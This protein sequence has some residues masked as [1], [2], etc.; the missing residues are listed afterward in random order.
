[1]KQCAPARSLICT[2]LERC[3]FLLQQQKEAKIIAYNPQVH[4]E[5]L[6]EFPV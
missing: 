4:R 3:V 2:D 6:A 5:F 1:M